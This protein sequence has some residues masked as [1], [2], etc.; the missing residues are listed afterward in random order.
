MRSNSTSLKWKELIGL[1]LLIFSVSTSSISNVTGSNNQSELEI[2]WDKTYGGPVNDGIFAA[3][4]TSDGGFALAGGT[5]SFSVGLDDMWFV[6]TD[7]AGVAQWNQTYGGVLR[8]FCDSIIQTTDGGYALFGYTI[9][10]GADLTNFWLVKTDEAGVAQWNQT[11][12]GSGFD[13]GM[14]VIQLTDGSFALCGSTSSHGAGI[15][16]FWL[17]KT[18]ANGVAQWNQTYGGTGFEYLIDAILTSDGGYALIGYTNSTG[19]GMDDAWL[20][21]INSNGVEEWNQTYGGSNIDWGLSIIQTSDGGYL[22]A[23]GAE[24]FGAGMSDMWLVKTDAAG[25]T[26]WSQNYGGITADWAADVISTSDGGYAV[27]GRTTSYGAGSGDIWLIKTNSSGV[28]QWNQTFGGEKEDS[29]DSVFQTS[30]G[31]YVIAGRTFSYG[32]GEEDM[33]LIMTKSAIPETSV[34]SGFGYFSFFVLF[35]VIL[36]YSKRRKK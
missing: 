18:N 22:L 5:Y 24:S 23:G 30:D 36:T 8:D 32:A 6:K 25:V 17:V 4:Q 28:A 14:V 7:A 29:V 10:N 1:S 21:K 13:D 20:V 12:G 9:S 2:Q 27:A 16:D 31:D 33:W 15:L 26:Q 34:I 19:S 3:V 11:Y 35:A